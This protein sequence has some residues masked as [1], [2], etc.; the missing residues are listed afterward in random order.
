MIKNKNEIDIIR[1]SIER[2]HETLVNTLKE[3]LNEFLD[4]DGSKLLNTRLIMEAT[5][6][7]IEVCNKYHNGLMKCLDKVIE[8]FDRETGITITKNDSGVDDRGRRLT[9]TESDLVAIQ[10]SVDTSE[11]DIGTL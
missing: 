8:R 2:Y 9:P 1:R 3:T 7:D 6:R 10:D 11:I 5:E 4:S